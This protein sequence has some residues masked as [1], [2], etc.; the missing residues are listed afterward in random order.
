M[1][2]LWGYVGV[3]EQRSGSL[4][5]DKRSVGQITNDQQLMKL[6]HA[7]S[8]REKGQILEAQTAMLLNS[9][10]LADTS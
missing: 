3:A 5:S 10:Q 1:L 9:G 7:S 4:C 2:S 8:D 6:E